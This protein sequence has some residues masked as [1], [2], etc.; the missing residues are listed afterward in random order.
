MKKS[1]H[2]LIVGLAFCLC[3]G[4]V[5][6]KPVD[7][8]TA[9]RVA[10]NCLRAY[11]MANPAAL[12][13]ITAQTPFTEF[14][15]FAAPQGGFAIVSADNCVRPI[16]GYSVG[17]RF[18]T[19]H[20]PDHIVSWLND[21]EA[22]I[23]HYRNLG[24]EST[25]W[26][27]VL[28]ERQMDP[29]ATPMV[30]T[31][32]TKWNQGNYYNGMCP[33]DTNHWTGHPYTGCVAT[34]MAQVMKFWNQPTTGYLSHGYNHD[35]GDTSYGWQYANFGATTYQW[36]NMP[37]KL[38]ASTSDIQNNAVAQLMYHVGVS[39]NMNYGITGSGAKTANRGNISIACQ[40]NALVGYFKYSPALH[41][42][43]R[44]DFSYDEW[45]SMLRADI[46]AGHPILYAGNDV[47]AGHS[48]VLDGYNDDG[49]FHL[50]WGW[51]GYCD[52]YYPIGGLNPAPGGAGGNSTSSYNRN[53]DA[54]IGIEP[55]LL[56]GNGGTITA[57]SSNTNWGAVEP[58][59]PFNYNFFDTVTLS[60]GPYNGYRFTGW[61]DGY[62]Y[63]YRSIIGTGGDYAYTANFKPVGSDTMMVYGSGG[64]MS[65]YGYGD[66]T[67][68]CTWGVKFD[69]SYFEPG[70]EMHTVEFYVVE[71]G[72][73]SLS[74]YLGTNSAEYLMA[75]TTVSIDSTETPL[76]K[77]VT[78]STPVV[79]NGRESMWI[80]LSNVDVGYPACV[81]NYS[82]IHE[83]FL[84][85][86]NFYPYG[87]R[88]NYSFMIRGLFRSTTS[89][90]IPH[91]VVSGPEQVSVGD[92]VV[93]SATGTTGDTITWNLP[94]IG[95]G[96]VS[97]AEARVV[98]DVDG[99]YTA[100][101][102]ITN[103]AG[104]SSDSASVIVVDYTLGDT[105]SYCLDRT[106]YGRV[107]EDT[108]TTRWGIMLP[109]NYLH[110]R[111]TL[112][113]VLLY[114]RNPGDYTLNVYQGGDNAPGQLV[115]SNTYTFDSNTYGYVSCTPA[116]PLN[117]DTTQN[118]WII[119]TYPDSG[120][121]P[122]CGS[123]YIGEPNSDWYYDS[124]NGSGWCHISRSF[125]RLA[126]TWL[127]KVVTSEAVTHTV[128]VNRV[129]ADGS[130]LDP[131][132]C[133]VTGEGTYAKGDTVTLTAAGAPDATDFVAWVNAAGD[134]IA[135]NP[136]TFVINSDVTLTA[137]FCSTVGIDG[138]ESSKITLYPNPASDAV[139]VN[140]LNGPA[141]VTI[142]DLN[143]REAGVW[144][145]A[146]GSVTLD[147][148]EFA[149]GE[150]FVRIAAEGAV[151]VR[152]L[153]VK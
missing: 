42:I 39:V 138:V 146:S 94:G 125:P 62:P 3:A 130:A 87:N 57:A 25:E 43:Y 29:P 63:I 68:E 24:V 76:W 126:R 112:H 88:Y 115:Y 9:R 92:T 149:A 152:K 72:V 19:K 64:Y 114:V 46:A 140:G 16:L 100:T 59:M 93:F 116:A 41:S 49:Y 147:L 77:S 131:T 123:Y 60:A 54:I 109:H 28:S 32:L 98:Y 75:D 18:E 95:G 144:R 118:L 61:S 119:F 27:M 8:T 137:V 104:S 33:N 35:N 96:I 121:Y 124:D 108:D 69:S 83:S 26:G 21:Y 20:M 102:T 151:A 129:M 22:E 15:I 80:G 153:V 34:S 91:I 99:T 133:T 127:I 110:S 30:D 23:R 103:A 7:E 66:T 14:Y 5:S 113:D 148:A 31:M 142:I 44:D 37:A 10:E 13:N 81:T 89:V 70:R 128:T 105:V 79:V 48:F 36:N 47:G 117:I 111:D 55:N 45:T 17:N 120:I 38:S 4:T 65:S 141:T 50:N 107:G 82:G 145:V 86:S 11:G 6:A 106:Y 12:V 53:N 139:V 136:Y 90:P 67:S 135:D 2:I 97:T 74:V 73:Y 143:G 51:G 1:L 84:W 78:L 71:P 52:G 101:A 56:W 85:G 58:A 134:S 132:M 150:Y 40:E 122:A